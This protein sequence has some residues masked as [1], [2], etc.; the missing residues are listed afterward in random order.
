MKMVNRDEKIQE[1]IDNLTAK[2]I[3]FV[4]TLEFLKDYFM[5]HLTA[6]L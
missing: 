4:D 5:Q 2:F 6:E 1:S 3:K